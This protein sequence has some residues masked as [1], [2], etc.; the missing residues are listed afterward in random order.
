VA[1]PRQFDPGLAAGFWKAVEAL[2]GYP[3]GESVRLRQM[4]FESNALQRLPEIL[5]SAGASRE[6]P[7]LVVMDE[8]PMRRAG[9]DLKP[10][11]LGI[12][13]RAGWSPEAVVAHPDA[14]GQV[15]T[16]F[17]QIE[18]AVQVETGLRGAVHRLRHDY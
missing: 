14:T 10:L 8:T 5:V 15:H 9:D 18:P 13:R 4:V 16:D 12:V 17:G 2:P 11:V 6:S 1:T 7:L 3:R